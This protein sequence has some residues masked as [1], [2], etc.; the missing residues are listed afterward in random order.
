MISIRSCQSKKNAKLSR[1]CELREA[2]RERWRQARTGGK[3][4]LLTLY[5]HY[6]PVYE[7]RTGKVGFVRGRESAS[8]ALGC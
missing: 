3:T 1:V 6:I 8:T 4:I 7:C 5:A 2:S